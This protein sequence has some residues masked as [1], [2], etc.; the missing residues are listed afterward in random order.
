[1]ERLFTLSVLAVSLSLCSCGN[2]CDKLVSFKCDPNNP[3]E[4]MKC[5]T[6]EKEIR[7]KCVDYMEKHESELNTMC[8]SKELKKLK[9]CLEQGQKKF[10][11]KVNEFSKTSEFHAMVCT[12]GSNLIAYRATL[13]NELKPI[14]RLIFQITSESDGKSNFYVGELKKGSEVEKEN[15]M[16]EKHLG[17]DGTEIRTLNKYAFNI[18]TKKSSEFSIEAYKGEK[19]RFLMDIP[20]ETASSFDIKSYEYCSGLF[21]CLHVSSTWNCK[22]VTYDEYTN[23]MNF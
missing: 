14:L 17:F 10:D 5:A 6:A 22:T 11:E 7:L 20:Y 18:M 2:P 15:L 9:P 16:G 21:T 12:E 1:M 23:L 4:L 19:V 13:S 3:D 8:E